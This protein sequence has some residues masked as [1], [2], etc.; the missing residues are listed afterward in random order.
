MDKRMKEKERTGQ[1]RKGLIYI[2]IIGV[3]VAAGVLGLFVVRKLYISRE[4]LLMA[5]EKERIAGIVCYGDS[6]T[7]GSGGEG[8]SYPLVLEEAL[9]KERIYIPVVNMGIGGENTVTIAGRAG[10]IPFQVEAFE[11]PGEAV[12]VEISFIEE[13]GK[14]IRPLYQGDT[15]LNPCTIG[16]VT[17]RITGEQD[18]Q[19][20]MTYFFTRS[21]EG[22]AV[23]VPEGSEVETW[24]ATQFQDYISVVF[25]GENHGWNDEIDEL[26]RQQQ[27]ILSMQEAQKG[28]FIVIGLP[29]GTAEERKELEAALSET[30][31][32]K[33]FNIREYM[34]TQALEDAGIKP[35]DEDK[36]RMAEGMV[37]SSLL[38]DHIHFNAEGYRLLGEQIYE[39]M[40]KLGYFEELEGIVEEYGSVF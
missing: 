31:G 6:L 25:M 26:I 30:Y 39:R 7:Y 12:P 40:K 34:S 29:T 13:E 3:L 8:V 33:F 36:A 9:R 11:I 16:G 32:D 19:G 23:K 5:Y 4:N 20:G 27:E 18:E 35:T 37:P 21:E 28:K 24:A 38:T 10:A 14:S 1:S 2:G 15:G 17:G 22:E